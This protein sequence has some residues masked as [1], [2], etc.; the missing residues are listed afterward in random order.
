MHKFNLI[1]MQG[2]TCDGNSMAVVNAINPDFFTFLEQNNI[3]LLYMPTISPEFGEDARKI[4][5]D[6]ISGKTPVHIFIFEGAIPTKDGFGDYFEGKDVKT[7]V[8]NFADQAMLTIALG[9]CAAFGGVPN[10][11]PNES[12][13]VGLQWDHY[14]KSGFLGKDY[15][16]MIGLPV[17]NIPGCPIHPDWFLLTL[18]SFVS[19][20]AI[21]LDKYNR[22][23]DFFKEKVHRG[24]N[25]CEFNDCNINA[26]EYTEIGCLEKIKGCKGKSINADCNIRLWYNVSSCTRSGH[27]CI[28]CTDPGFPGNMMPFDKPEKGIKEEVLERKAINKRG[29]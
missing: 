25:A 21:E 5:D 16:S 29:E 3:N 28:G 17:V 12:G 8:K 10:T 18:Q 20:K 24:C 19:G 13:A 26:P 23:K 15:V 27:P 7:M 1:W 22:P 9:S 4:F 14:S 11:P 6:C 2:Q